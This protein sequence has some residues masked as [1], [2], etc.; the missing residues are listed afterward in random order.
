M[1]NFWPVRNFVNSL[2][3]FFH[4]IETN[5]K[6]RIYNVEAAK[7]S[8]K[9]MSNICIICQ[10]IM[11]CLLFEINCINELSTQLELMKNRTHKDYWNLEECTVPFIVY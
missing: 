11:M 7:S 9:R 3:C 8:H 2:T 4:S 10:I 6:K 5:A 1:A